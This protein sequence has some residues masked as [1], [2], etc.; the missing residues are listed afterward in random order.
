MDKPQECFWIIWSPTGIKPPSYKHE[1]YNA[2]VQEAERLA[3]F[4]GGSEFFVMRA[5]TMRKVDD[6]QRVDYV[7]PDDYVPF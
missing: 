3:R 4:H 7:H 2:A 5:E 6:M 1:S